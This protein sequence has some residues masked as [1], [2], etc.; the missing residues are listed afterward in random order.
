MLKVVV[1]IKRELTK[2]CLLKNELISGVLLLRT[3]RHHHIRI[4]QIKGANKLFM[5]IFIFIKNT[6]IDTD[7]D[8][9]QLNIN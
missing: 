9:S 8:I 6:N 1:L 3:D 5:I 2:A 4:S 7:K